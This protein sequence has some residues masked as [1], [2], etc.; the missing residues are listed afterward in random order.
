VTHRYGVVLVLVVLSFVVQIAAPDDD[1]TR[2]LIVW[3]QAITLVLTI[4][5]AEASR[6]IVRVGAALAALVAVAAPVM[7]AVHGSIPKGAAAITTALL[8]GI[9]PAVIAAGLVR[10]QR[11]TGAVT[12][13]A[14]SGV[15]S[16]YLLVGMFFSFLFAAVSVLGDAQF[17]EEVAA[18]DR[19]DFL[20]FSYTTLTTT[21]YGD[22]TAATDLGRTLAVTEALI[23]QIY[24]VTVVALIITN[25]RPRRGDRRAAAAEEDL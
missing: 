14:L 7:W 2:L 6:A 4:R 24:L 8:V 3:L 12:V 25:L 17:F 19:A 5:I 22:F 15:L 20:Y 1:L 11:T 23:G 21:G 18:P 10:E 13:E 9:A 16:I